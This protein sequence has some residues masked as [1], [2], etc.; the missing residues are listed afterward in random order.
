MRHLE[1]GHSLLEALLMIGLFLWLILMINQ[2]MSGN[3]R[4]VKRLKE[5][6]SLRSEW[7]NKSERDNSRL[8]R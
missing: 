5:E 4:I 6:S 8:D 7:I 3:W 1:N 2:S